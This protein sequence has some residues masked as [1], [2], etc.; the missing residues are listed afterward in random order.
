MKNKNNRYFTEEKIFGNR[1]DLRITDP[2]VLSK[3]DIVSRNMVTN[4]KT[5]DTVGILKI[6]IL[7]QLSSNK[8]G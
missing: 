2:G 7:N 3:D 5:S 8:N 4:L 6:D 1:N